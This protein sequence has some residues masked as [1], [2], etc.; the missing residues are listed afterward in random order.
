MDRHMV[1][2]TRCSQNKPDSL[3]RVGRLADHDR[4]DTTVV[5]VVVVVSMPVQGTVVVQM[6]TLAVPGFVAA[7]RVYEQAGTAAHPP[8]RQAAHLLHVPGEKT[9]QTLAVAVV[10]PCSVPALK[11]R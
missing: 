7:D 3:H 9:A 10:Y 5:A 4:V 8:D 1:A 6:Y 2:D 11:E